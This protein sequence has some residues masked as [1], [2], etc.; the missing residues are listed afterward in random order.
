VVPLD[1]LI[2]S[3]DH[4]T[5]ADNPEYDQRLQNRSRSTPLSAALVD[6]RSRNFA[7]RATA[8]DSGQIDR[9]LPIVGADSMVESG[10]GRTMA[11]KKVRDA[12]GSSWSDYQ[13]QVRTNAAQY[14]IDP[15]QLDGIKDPVLVRER[16]T[17]MDDTTRQNF[18][19]EANKPAIEKLGSYDQGAQDAKH[20]SPDVLTNIRVGD[21]STVDQAIASNP[22]LI[23]DFVR[24]LPTDQ[25]QGLLTEDMTQLTAEGRARVKNA[26][27]SAAYPGAE[28]RALATALQEGVGEEGK[29]VVDAFERNAPLMAR[30]QARI[31]QG[32]TSPSLSITGDLAKVVDLL[33]RMRQHGIHLSYML[34]GAQKVTAG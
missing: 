10:N 26:L 18:A 14:G 28:G 29:N 12:N 7:S 27:I 15:A 1:S 33:T 32:I 13:A 17:P 4:V 25:R 21:A 19:E 2:T 8:T 34:E 3:N 16:T 20:I 11:L 23:Q 24:S 30:L 9:G 5:F 31:A 6:E 22:K